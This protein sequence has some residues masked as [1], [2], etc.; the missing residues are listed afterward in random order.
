MPFIY[1]IEG[2]GPYAHIVH[3]IFDWLA[4]AKGKAVTATTTMLELLVRPYQLSNLDLVNEFYALFSTYPN[5]TWAE[6]TLEIADQAA[7]IRA[8]H[9]LRTPD[10]IQA[11]TALVAG[12]TGFVTNDEVFSRVET[13]DVLLLQNLLE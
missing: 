13:L 3:P 5:L 7:R 10:A 9:K 1:Q 12:A 4:K 2:F 8:E 6:L 11:A